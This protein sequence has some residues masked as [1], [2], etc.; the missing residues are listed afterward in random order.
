[1][2]E[3]LGVGLVCRIQQGVNPDYVLA[4]VCDMVPALVQLVQRRL[5][6]VP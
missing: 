5:N 1:M 4:I 3:V 6:Q 2:T